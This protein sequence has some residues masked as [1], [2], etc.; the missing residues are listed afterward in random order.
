[1]YPLTG[2]CPNGEKE[3]LIAGEK[4]SESRGKTLFLWVYFTFHDERRIFHVERRTFRDE[5]RTFH[6]VKHKI[7][8]GRRTFITASG[9]FFVC[10]GKLLH[11]GTE[12]PT[13]GSRNFYAL[14]LKA[15]T[16]GSGNTFAPRFN[17]IYK[18][19]KNRFHQ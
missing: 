12:A 16:A 10:V 15:H 7:E 19:L 5:R 18:P 8:L 1:M 14:L 11:P 17:W 2:F 3:F 4:V 9:N 13:S 6:A